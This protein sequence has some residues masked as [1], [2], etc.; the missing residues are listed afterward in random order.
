MGVSFFKGSIWE[1]PFGAPILGSSFGVSIWSGPFFKGSIW[2]SPF[3]VTILGPPFGVLIL[4][5]PFLGVP[6]RV[7]LLGFPFWGSIWGL[8]TSRG[9]HFWGPL[10]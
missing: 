5:L 2:G 1:S 7:P 9:A 4:G 3:G 10:F 6:Y 8:L